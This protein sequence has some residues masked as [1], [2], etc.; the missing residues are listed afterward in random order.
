VPASSSSRIRQ[1]AFPFLPKRSWR[2]R[3]AQAHPTQELG[4]GL[5]SKFCPIEV[6]ERVIE[7]CG[8][9]EKRVRLLPAWLVVYGLVMLCLYPDASYQ[10]VLQRM[11]LG[12]STPRRWQVPN[13]SALIQARVKLG[14]E[15]MERL[16]RALTAPLARAGTQGCF[17]RGLRVM[18]I[19]GTTMEVANNPANEAAF[20]G[21]STTGRQRAGNPQIRIATLTECGTHAVVDAGMGRY[22]ED[23]LSLMSRFAPSVNSEMLL[24]GDRKLASTKL[25][26]LLV[27][28]DAHLLWRAPR[29]VATKLNKD[30]SDGSYL[31]VI[32]RKEKGRR[33]KVTVRVVEYAV[34]GSSEI[35]RLITS[36]LDPSTAPAEE[37]ARLYHQR[38]EVEGAFDELK[39]HQRGSGAVLRSQSPQGVRQEF[40]AH[41]ILHGIVRKLAY[42]ASRAVADADPDRISFVASLQ[43]IRR[44]ATGGTGCLAHLLHRLL[45]LALSELTQL[46][47]LVVR[48]HRQCPRV[49]GHQQP[50]YPSRRRP[51]APSVTFGQPPKIF[52][53]VPN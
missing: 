34:E 4:F 50:R 13:K 49:V 47:L 35:Y 17:W 21:P 36:L 25:W 8:R 12:A 30:L 26:T 46:R 45:K 2:R 52:V 20:G 16:F 33:F 6:V 23:E 18:A 42:Q 1:I 41:M 3:L 44:T 14:W 32:F 10:E 27:E 22:K 19:D 7:E 28:Q 51:V 38:W 31:S 37:L 48:R 53:L 43:V 39:T 15:V 40:W 11:A 29:T 24:L 5:I 9:K